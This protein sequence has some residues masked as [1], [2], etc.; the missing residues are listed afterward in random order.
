M[1]TELAKG[2]W[3]GLNLDEQ[4]E[5]ALRDKLSERLDSGGKN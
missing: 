4:I 1:N 5:A 3:R 2:C